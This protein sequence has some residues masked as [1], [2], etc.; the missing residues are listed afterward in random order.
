MTAIF[1]GEPT[2]DTQRGLRKIGYAVPDFKY[3]AWL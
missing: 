3:G 2:Y 1:Q